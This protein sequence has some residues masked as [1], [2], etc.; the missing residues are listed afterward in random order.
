MRLWLQFV[1]SLDVCKQTRVEWKEKLSLTRLQTSWFTL[2]EDIRIS[3]MINSDLQELQTLFIC[4]QECFAM[5]QV[6]LSLW[7][8]FIEFL[9]SYSRCKVTNGVMPRVLGPT[10]FY[11]KFWVNI[12][13]SIMLLC[14]SSECWCSSD[15]HLGSS[16]MN[17]HMNFWVGHMRFIWFSR[18][19]PWV[20]TFPH[21]S[22]CCWIKLNKVAPYLHWI[23]CRR[24]NSGSAIF[25]LML[26]W[27]MQD[28]VMYHISYVSFFDWSGQDL[29]WLCF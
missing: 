15:I 2:Q 4:F 11:L 12:L 13:I 29:L 17:E 20:V 24:E 19:Y 16:F 18:Q 9:G 25:R 1:W 6:M 10:N 22:E 8:L 27:D 5:V 14:S 3:V 23:V 28:T 21:A 26:L 7:S